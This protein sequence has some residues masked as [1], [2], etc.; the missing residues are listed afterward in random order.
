MI[1]EGA[2]ENP[3]VTRVLGFHEGQIDASIKSGKI[4][5]RQGPMMASMDRFLIEVKGKGNHGG[6]IRKIREIQLL[7]LLK[8]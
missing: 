6:L 4:A 1:K 3:K 7:P 8:L 2:M 5:Y